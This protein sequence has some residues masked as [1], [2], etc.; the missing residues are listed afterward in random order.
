ML[1]DFAATLIHGQRIRGAIEAI[2]TRN[3]GHLAQLVEEGLDPNQKL[4]TK[5]LTEMARQG[6][7]YTT[8]LLAMSMYHMDGYNEQAQIQRDIY[9]L[10]LSKGGDPFLAV[11]NDKRNAFDHLANIRNLAGIQLIADAG[12]DVRKAN[13]EVNKINWER[14]AAWA[15]EYRAQKD[16]LDLA[17]E[18]PETP[19][20]RARHRF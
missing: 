13:L 1:F 14:G 19:A 2:E 7:K 12:V 8:P 18:T 6:A 4:S 17:Q 9:C 15:S 5:S 3:W 10:L 16:A 20:A 11:G